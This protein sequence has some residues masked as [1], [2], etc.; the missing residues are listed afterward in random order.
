MKRRSKVIKR[1]KD[2]KLPRNFWNRLFAL[3]LVVCGILLALTALNSLGEK[4]SW[5]RPD[6]RFQ[7]NTVIIET[8]NVI[9]VSMPEIIGNE[10]CQNCVSLTLEAQHFYPKERRLES[11]S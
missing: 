8:P 6:G 11:V 10:N 4:V 9:D 5:L 3:F 2:I 1:L 7:D